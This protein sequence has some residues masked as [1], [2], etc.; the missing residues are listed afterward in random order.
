MTAKMKMAGLAV[1]LMGLLSFSAAYADN[2]PMGGGNMHK[3]WHHEDKGKRLGEVLNLTESQDK[4]L[5]ALHEQQR[6]QMK[7]V[8]EQMKANRQDFEAEIAKEKPD[9][10][11][12]NDLQTKLKS[13][14]AQ[15]VDD[16]LNG[17][18]AVKKILTPQQFAGYMALKKERQMKMMHRMHERFEH[19]VNKGGEYEK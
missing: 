9:M 17:I 8:F 18:L 15:M 5:Q 7:A 11:K 4:Q 1:A 16:H 3:G 12:I 13:I 6:T 2:G 14:Q 10:N 19:G